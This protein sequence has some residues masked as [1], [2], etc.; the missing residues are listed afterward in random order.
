MHIADNLKL[1]PENK[2]S[3]I[4]PLY[5]MTNENLVQVEFFYI[6]FSTDE[7]MVP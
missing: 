3:K 7:S 5:D 2:M 1:T 4:S 6:L